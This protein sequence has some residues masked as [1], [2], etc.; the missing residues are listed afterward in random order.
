MG[1]DAWV[2]CADSIDNVQLETPFIFTNEPEKGVQEVAYWRK[3][4]ELQTW[5]YQLYKKK[6]GT[7]DFNCIN[8]VLTLE[9]LKE[10]ETDIQ[11][12]LFRCDPHDDNSVLTCIE[13]AKECINEGKI[14]YYTSWW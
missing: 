13:S 6:G 11:S 1:L 4:H 12:G 3:L 10:L 7:E 8:L 14:V 5:M 2:R 9:D